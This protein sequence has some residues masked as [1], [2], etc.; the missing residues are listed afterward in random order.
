MHNT[1]IYCQRAVILG[2]ATAYVQYKYLL[3]KSSDTGEGYSM[4]C[5]IQIFTVKEQ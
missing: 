1:N 3:S 5:A 4:I 2:K